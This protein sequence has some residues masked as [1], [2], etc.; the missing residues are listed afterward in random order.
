MSRGFRRRGAVV[1]AALAVLSTATPA[2]AHEQRQVGAYQ[3]TV[4]WQ[5]EPT[6]TGQLNAVQLLVKDAKGNAIDDL[7]DPPSVQVTVTTGTETSSPLDL[8]AS[9]DPDT[10]LGT[11]GELD[12][13]IMPTTPGAYTFHLTGTIK[14]QKIDEKFTSSAGTFDDVKDPTDIQFPSKLPNTA[15]LATG[16]TRLSPR[17]DRALAASRSAHD[18][19]TSDATL[20]VVALVVGT[21][22]GL[23]GIVR[24]AA[25]RRRKA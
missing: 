12:A 25:G 23:G 2:F 11:H 7:G 21:V 24:G 3:L 22:L 10:G 16:I 8:K 14:G 18:K 13:D 17:V 15:D 20:A 19:A 5:H 4:G 1:V 6:F 9:W